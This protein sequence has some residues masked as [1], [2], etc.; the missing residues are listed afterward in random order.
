ML[1]LRSLSLMR[2]ASTDYLGRFMVYLDTLMCLEEAVTTK[3]ASRKSSGATAV[4]RQGLQ[5]PS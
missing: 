3:T 1:V 5:S 2:E 4:K